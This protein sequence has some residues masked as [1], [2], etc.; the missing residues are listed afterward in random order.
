LSAVGPAAGSCNKLILI[1]ALIIMRRN[2]VTTDYNVQ[3][4]QEGARGENGEGEETLTDVIN[5]SI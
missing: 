5:L 4:L 3:T 1:I 2:I